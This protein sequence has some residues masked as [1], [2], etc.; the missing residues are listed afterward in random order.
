MLIGYSRVS[1][2]DQNL[3]S[4]VDELIQAGCDP[5]YIFTDVVSGATDVS[6]LTDN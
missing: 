1:T 6:Y 5:K 2:H 3:D 4:Q